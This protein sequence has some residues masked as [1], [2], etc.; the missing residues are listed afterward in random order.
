VGYV[1]RYAGD[2]FL[3]QAVKW[4]APGQLTE[5]E[6]FRIDRSSGATAVNNAGVIVGYAGTR[7]LRW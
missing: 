3:T 5:L 7:A 6:P 4:T 1:S 2:I